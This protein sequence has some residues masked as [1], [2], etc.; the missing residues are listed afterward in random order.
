MSGPAK[1]VMGAVTVKY[2]HS[3]DPAKTYEITQ[4][5]S[6]LTSQMVALNIV[7]KG[8]SVQTSQ[9][10]GNTVYIYGSSND[11]AWVNNGV[12]YTI[13]DKASLRSDQLIKI[14]QGLNP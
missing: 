13:K 1:A 2:T 5:Q 10:A 12:L 11:A 9:I 14:V 7:P 4:A 6:N 8:A 3:K